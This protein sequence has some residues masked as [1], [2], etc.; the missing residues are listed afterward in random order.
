MM[1]FL[2]ALKAKPV[3]IKDYKFIGYMPYEYGGGGFI[4][5]LPTLGL[6]L[7]WSSVIEDDLKKLDWTERSGR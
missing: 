6:H 2:R 1:R 4:M 7:D 3:Y 5:L